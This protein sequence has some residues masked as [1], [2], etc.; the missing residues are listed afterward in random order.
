MAE[1]IV[2]INQNKT[3][4]LP[5]GVIERLA[6]K[7][8]DKMVIRLDNVEE[9]MVVGKLPMDA[10]EKAPEIDNTLGQKVNIDDGYEI[11]KKGPNP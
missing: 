7:H 6:L 11:A 1:Y 3:I 5:S 4:N 10:L 9:H 2:E 8:G